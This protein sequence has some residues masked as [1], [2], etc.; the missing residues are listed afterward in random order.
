MSC[1]FRH[2][3]LTSLV[4]YSVTKLKGELNFICLIHC[5][6]VCFLMLRLHRSLHIDL[7]LRWSQTSLQ[8]RSK[9][10]YTP[11]LAF[12]SYS[13]CIRKRFK[14]TLR[15]P[16]Y[17]LFQKYQQDVHMEQPDWISELA[18]KRFLCDSP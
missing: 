16:R 4:F 13:S 6:N 8:Q 9:Y 14:L 12:H 15:T 18:F 11:L 17:A 10:T 7:K 3:K 2:S 1:T 5:K